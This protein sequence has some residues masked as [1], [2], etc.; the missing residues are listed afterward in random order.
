[1]LRA[2]DKAV[3]E[4]GDEK[5]SDAEF[6]AQMAKVKEAASDYM[7]AKRAQKGYNS[8]D[9]SQEEIDKRMLGKGGGASIFTSK[10]KERYAFAMDLIQ[11]ITN[12]EKAMQE[13][14]RKKKQSH[15]MEK[16]TQ[17][18]DLETQET[19]KDEFMF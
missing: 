15:P 19:E 9:M 11:E 5:K 12:M 17:V 8:K 14:Q 16:E 18:K 10:G 7:N 13:E 3:R 4:L 6:L 1:M 2:Y